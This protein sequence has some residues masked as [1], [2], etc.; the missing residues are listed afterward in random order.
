MTFSPGG[1]TVSRCGKTNSSSLTLG[2]AKVS[3]RSGM[4]IGKE[5][6]GET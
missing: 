4:S 1:M 3:R 2:G 5:E 6:P